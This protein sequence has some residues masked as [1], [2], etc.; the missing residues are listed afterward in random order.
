MI[1]ANALSVYL[2]A[3]SKALVQ[4]IKLSLAKGELLAI[5][6]PNGAG[7]STLLRAIA[8]LLPTTGTLRV[9]GSDP[10]EQP[11]HVVA[12]YMAFLAQHVTFSFSFSVLE[13]VLMGRYVHA[14]HPFWG[15]ENKEDHSFALQALTQCDVQHLVHRNFQ[16]LSGG[17]QRRVLIAQALCQGAQLLLLDEPTAGL[18]PLH[19][20]NL[21]A[22]M[23]AQCNTENR[24]VLMV[25][26]DLN[27][28][29]RYT[30]KV[31]LLHKGQALAFAAPKTVFASE[32][33][34]KAF[35]L[36]LHQGLIGNIPFAVPY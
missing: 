31:L 34:Q 12:K 18:D 29:L 28:A 7:K 30:D 8:G 24:G 20:R 9:A 21:F 27:L 32:L 1:Q 19:A 5:V 13:V 36:Q 17:E 23:R 15:G 14:S 4:N 33:M 22:L 6:G 26:H 2:T 3:N 35:S 25:T 16:E 11:R 10:W